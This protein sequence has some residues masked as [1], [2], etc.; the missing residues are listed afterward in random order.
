MSCAGVFAKEQLDP[1]FVKSEEE[2]VTS[3][4]LR[5]RAVAATEPADRGVSA[6][7]M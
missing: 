3:A 1:E 6:C 2:R 7:P 4:Y 5:L